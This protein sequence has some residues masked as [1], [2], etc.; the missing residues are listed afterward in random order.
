MQN[1]TVQI[2]RRVVFIWMTLLLIYCIS[3][4]NGFSTLKDE[5]ITEAFIPLSILISGPLVSFIL[6]VASLIIEQNGKELF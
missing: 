3:C 2:V 4:V 6:L 1:K 5:D